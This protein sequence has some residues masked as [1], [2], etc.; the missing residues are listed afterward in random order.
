MLFCQSNSSKTL[1]K[2]ARMPTT[3]RMQASLKQLENFGSFSRSLYTWFQVLTGESWSEAV[4]RPTIW[5]YYD[6]SYRA[7][8]SGLFFVLYVLITN[9]VLTN[10][11]VAVLLDKMVD[12][13]VAAAATHKDP[14]DEEEEGDGK[15]DGNCSNGEEDKAPPTA[16]DLRSTMS[17]V[18]DQVEQL[19][20]VSERMSSELDSFKTEMSSMRDQLASLIRIA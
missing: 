12:P 8:G 5:F 16:E 20:T 2:A 4:A 10:V 11:V 15:G 1:V 19:M 7:V 18:T 17:N 6:S 9:F 14:G 3:L 13:E